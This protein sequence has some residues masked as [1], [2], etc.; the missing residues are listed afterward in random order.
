MT[1]S[2]PKRNRDLGARDN[3]LVFFSPEEPTFS[4]HSHFPEVRTQVSYISKNLSSE[5]PDFL[6][7]MVFPQA[8]EVLGPP[9]SPSP[10][11]TGRPSFSLWGQNA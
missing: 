8:P 1:A 4:G 6:G 10:G 2:D 9:T 5:M 11:T 7:L 3:I